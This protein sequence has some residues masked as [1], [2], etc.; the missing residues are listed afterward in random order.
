MGVLFVAAQF[1]EIAAL[2]RA[3]CDV[4]EF[5]E[6]RTLGASTACVGC[7]GNL[8]RGSFREWDLWQDDFRIGADFQ[9]EWSRCVTVKDVGREEAGLSRGRAEMDEP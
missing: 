7:T 8:D 6:N 4:L 9:F 2:L 3:K 1:C 5:E